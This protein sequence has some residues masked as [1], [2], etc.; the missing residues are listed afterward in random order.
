M[1]VSVKQRKLIKVYEQVHT[2]AAVLMHLVKLTNKTCILT[3]TD[4][5]RGICTDTDP[6]MFNEM[7]CT[8]RVETHHCRLTIM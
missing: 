1:F 4:A 5:Q 6:H 2:Q 7:W 8:Q 3:Y